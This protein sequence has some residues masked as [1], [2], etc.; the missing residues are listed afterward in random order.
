MSEKPIKA[1]LNILLSP[2][3][4]ARNTA[5]TEKKLTLR[6]QAL[7]NG[8]TASQLVAEWSG[9]IAQLNCNVSLREVANADNI[10][11]L[12]DVNRS[13][14]NSTSIQ[15]ITEHL[16]SVFR[17]A[18]VELTDAQL[19]E[20]ALSI[21]AA[22]WYLNLAELCLFFSQLKSGSR[23]QF[24]WG[25]KINNQAVMVALADFCKDRRREIEKKET[26]MARQKA[27]E[28]YYRN[29]ILAKDIVMGVKAVEKEREKA[30]R[31]YNAFRNFFPYLPEEYDPV[32]L[33]KAF[34]EDPGD[35]IGKWL[36]N[37][38][39]Y[40]AKQQENKK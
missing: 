25:S 2:S 34:A 38:N 7:R 9:T 18:G 21:L 32:Q 11:T 31:D 33:W 19:A 12:T 17:Y 13:F 10:P 4:I 6:Q 29:E 15:I 30:K 39:I 22:Y 36:C 3:Q 28:G 20:T 35:K 24:V 40:R 5:I 27:E 1:V 16:K 8:S 23:G 14:S 37:I 26:E